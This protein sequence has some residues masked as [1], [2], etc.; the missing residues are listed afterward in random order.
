[1][2]TTWILCSSLRNFG[3]DFSLSFGILLAPRGQ[4]GEPRPKETAIMKREKLFL[5]ALVLVVLLTLVVSSRAQGPGV[6][7]DNGGN[8]VTCPLADN[9]NTGMTCYSATLAGCS[10][11]Q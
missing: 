8:S 5:S 3:F 4:P 1:M 6:T 11:A 9:F 10:N 2:W 7:L